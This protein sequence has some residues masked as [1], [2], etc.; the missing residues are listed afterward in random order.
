MKQAVIRVNDPYPPRKVLQNLNGLVIEMRAASVIFA[1]AIAAA[2]TPPLVT[3]P[4]FSG[5]TGAVTFP[6]S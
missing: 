2:L 5:T 4:R 1:G 6:Y 3:Y